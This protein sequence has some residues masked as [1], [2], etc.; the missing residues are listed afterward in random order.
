M[1]AVT[2]PP[3]QSKI[4]PRGVDRRTNMPMLFAHGTGTSRSSRPG[5]RFVTRDEVH[6]P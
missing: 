3:L 4:Q 1:M 2:V 5:T 6:W